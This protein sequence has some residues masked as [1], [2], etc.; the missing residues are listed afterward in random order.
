MRE[1]NFKVSDADAEI[2]SQIV[3]RGWAIN[4]LRASY[5][6]KLSMRMDVM[7]VHANGNRLRLADLLAADDFNFAHDI[8][9]IR[10]CLDRDTGQM[11]NCFSPRFSDHS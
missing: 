8:F 3:K 9:G 6:D 11:M 2:I 7:A 4:W 5:A 10:N 1:V